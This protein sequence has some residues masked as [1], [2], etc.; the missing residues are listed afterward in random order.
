[1]WQIACNESFKPITDKRKLT[2]ELEHNTRK[3]IENASLVTIEAINR[4]SLQVDV[5]FLLP[6]AVRGF[7]DGPH[8]F[9]LSERDTELH[10]N[11]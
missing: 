6:P 5:K 4:H 11:N 2:L 8:K 3:I 9:Q 10:R 1:L 7:T